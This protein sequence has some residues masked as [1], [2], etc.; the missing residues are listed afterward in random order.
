MLTIWGRP[1]SINVQKVMWTVLHL[2]LEHDRIDAGRQYGR[3]DT[4]EY[5]AMNP[6]RRVPVLQDGDLTLFESNTIVRYLAATYDE[7]GLWPEDPAIRAKSELWMDWAIYHLMPPMTGLLLQLYRTP[8][9]ERDMA[10]VAANQKAMNELMM[11]V[12]QALEGRPY[13]S[14]ETLGL[15]DIATGTA[16]YR[17]FTFGLEKPEFRNLETYY[18]RLQERPEFREAVMIPLS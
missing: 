1:N 13:V 18:A 11:V 8:E 17:F 16:T 4:P 12:D 7:G 9:S 14:G 15:G 3:T 5:R 2:G 10:G 6:M